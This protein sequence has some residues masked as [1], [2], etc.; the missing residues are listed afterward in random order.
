MH[1]A[2][3]EQ[4]LRREAIRRHLAGEPRGDICRALSRTTRWFDKWWAVY[5]R[6]PTSDLADRSRAPHTSPTQVPVDLARAVVRIRR[7][8]EA[9][10]TPA[11]RYSPIGGRTIAG[12]LDTL[13]FERIPSLSSIQRILQA[14][15]LTHP[16]GAGEPKAYY[17]W[18]LAWDVNVIQAT[19]IITRHVRGGLAIENFHTIDHFSHAIWLGQYDCQTAATT[20][21]FLLENWAN[22]GLPH[23][24]QFD[25]ESA[26]C[27]GHTHRRVI[28]Q[29]V[30][31][32]LFCG[33]EPIFTP[34]YDARRN[35][36]IETFH[37]LWLRFFWSR[38]QFRDLAHV[39]QL[40]PTFRAWWHAH[41]RPP[42]LEGLTPGQVRH[43]VRLRLLTPTLQH[44][45]PAG[46]LPITTGRIHFMR[47]VTGEGLIHLLNEPWPVDR[48]LAGDAKRVR[49]TVNVAEQRLTIW[50]QV[51]ADRPW[52]RLKTRQFRLKEPVHDLLPAFR[53]KCARCLD[54]YPD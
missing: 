54:Y 16:L 47:K 50:R 23:F 42:A 35:Y 51:D 37:S 48:K 8:L 36:Q 10:K 4:A 5:Q 19:D 11:T 49:A 25:N 53:Q 41:Y 6:D 44:L 24:H 28:G 45:I 9:A 26:F 34:F 52:Q 22:L 43:G 13:G 12:Q 2:T 30:R 29:V 31:L 1:S 3:S 46:R 27:G 14:E 15:G 38:H 20:R 32:C 17:P 33:V 21:L 18:P 39:R 7:T 40:S